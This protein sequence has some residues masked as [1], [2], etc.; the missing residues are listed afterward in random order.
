MG[1]NAITDVTEILVDNNASPSTPPAD[2][3]TIY[4]NG[5]KLKYKDDTGTVYEMVRTSPTNSN[6]VI[7]NSIVNTGVADSEDV[8]IGPEASVDATAFIGSTSVGFRASSTYNGAVAI[9]NTST[10]AGYAVP[11]AKVHTRPFSKM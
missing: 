6:I 3:I 11:S 10:A 7:G 9:G 2:S 4:A 8:I 1:N 5:D